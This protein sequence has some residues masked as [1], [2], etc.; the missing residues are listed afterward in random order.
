MKFPKKM[1]ENI[2]VYKIFKKFK[3]MIRIYHE[4]SSKF[5]KS[6]PLMH[7]IYISVH[8]VLKPLCRFYERLCFDK[9]KITRQKKKL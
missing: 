5:L 2:W 1:I 6:T 3:N 4:Y 9:I 7:M 8:Y